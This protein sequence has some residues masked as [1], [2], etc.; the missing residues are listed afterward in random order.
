MSRVYVDG[1]GYVSPVD[2]YGAR[3][4][5][6]T[7]VDGCDVSPGPYGCLVCKLPQCRY[8][9]PFWYRAYRKGLRDEEIRA[10]CHREGLKP[11]QAAAR[12]KLSKSTVSRV[13]GA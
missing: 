13:L 9:S 12:F 11:H 5:S 2:T 6:D 4:E 8:D 7:D 1:V 10:T 3:L